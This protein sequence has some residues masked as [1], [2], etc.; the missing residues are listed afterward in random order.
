MQVQ[1]LRVSHLPIG[2]SPELLERYKST[3][4]NHSL[5]IST[6]QRSIWISS[7]SF[8]SKLDIQ[9][10][11]NLETYSGMTAYYFLLRVA[12]GLESRIAGE[13]DI[14]GQIKEAWRENISSLNPLLRT[15]L[16]PWMQ[17]LFEDAKEVRSTY[18]QKL[19]G[20][21]YG[22]LVRKIIHDHA[23][24]EK[25]PVLLIG[26]GRI[27]RSV[28]P[29]L[30]DHELWIWN[31]SPEKLM[32]LYCSLADKGNVKI[33][34]NEAGLASAW[35]TA[36]HA[37]ICVPVDHNKESERAAM[38]RARQ[39]S[40]GSVTHLGG[41]KTQCTAWEAIEGFHSLDDIFD[42]HDAQGKLRLTQIQ[43]AKRACEE[44]AKLRALGG[45]LSIPHGWEDL[46]IFA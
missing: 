22:T 11:G 18:L 24:K 31:R 41:Y 40:S 6:C 34:D 23:E 12:T 38:W 17:H 9:N 13:T 3:L 4:K 19:G 14:F 2:H 28:T 25:E 30:L 20:V 10:I 32:S 42:L 15:E 7:D 26:A 29:F 44:R 45:S 1:S 16:Q 37:I 35:A 21:S 27:A 43:R 46:A 39:N 36:P 33:I 5:F 8:F